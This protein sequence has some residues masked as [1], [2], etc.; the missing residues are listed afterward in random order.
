MLDERPA[1]LLHQSGDQGSFLKE[2]PYEYTGTGIDLQ[3]KD[4]RG[5]IALAPDLN[6]PAAGGKFIECS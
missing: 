5:I 3:P 2:E 1:R 6:S 4:T